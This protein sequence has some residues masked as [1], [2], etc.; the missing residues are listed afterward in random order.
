M[1]CK[2]ELDIQPMLQIH[3]ELCFNISDKSQ[4]EKIKKTMENCMELNVP[5]VVDVAIGKNF[6]EAV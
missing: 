3:D 4:I 2:E 5:S 1:A 6:G